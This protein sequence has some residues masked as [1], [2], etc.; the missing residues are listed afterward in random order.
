MGNA[1]FVLGFG[2]GLEAEQVLPAV[3]TQVQAQLVEIVEALIDTILLDDQYPL[4]QVQNTVESSAS[5]PR[6]CQ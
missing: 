2:D 1:I 6:L 4:T 3:G 5:K